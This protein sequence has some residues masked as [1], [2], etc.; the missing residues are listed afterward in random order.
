ML[1]NYNTVTNT[2]QRIPHRHF[3]HHGNDGP[4]TRRTGKQQQ[5]L[6]NPALGGRT[7]HTGGHG[8]G[9]TA[10]AVDLCAV[11]TRFR[12]TGDYIDTDRSAN[13]VPAPRG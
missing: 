9:N 11:D 7:N 13:H 2:R 4:C 6:T 5:R 12:M 1:Y 10:E 8:T 3:F